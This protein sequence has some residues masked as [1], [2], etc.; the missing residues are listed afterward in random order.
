MSL[1]YSIVLPLTQ[2]EDSIVLPLT[3]SEEVSFLVVEEVHGLCRLFGVLLLNLSCDWV[4]ELNDHVHLTHQQR[5]GRGEERGGE[6][7]GRGEERG[8]RGG[9]R[10]EE[11][12]ERGGERGDDHVH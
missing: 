5:E 12:G 11:R 2:S 4:L 8:E 9:E 6:G 10:G 1:R 7:E 3:Q